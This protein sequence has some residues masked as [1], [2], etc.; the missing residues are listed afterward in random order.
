[1]PLVLSDYSLLT[2]WLLSGC[3]LSALWV[4]SD[5][6]L[7]ADLL[8]TACLKIWARIKKIDFSR[9]FWNG[10]RLWLL[11]LLSEPKTDMVMVSIHIS[12]PLTLTST[13]DADKPIHLRFF[14]LT[15]CF[16]SFFGAIIFL[17]SYTVIHYLFMFYIVPVQ[18]N[19]SVKTFLIL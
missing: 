18:C 3:F 9:Q 15:H 14:H 19:A 4:L 1:M 17:S 13:W 16:T 12:L 11:G 8:L 2:L 6:S 5:C 10:R 7:T